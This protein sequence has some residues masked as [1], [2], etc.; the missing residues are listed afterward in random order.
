MLYVRI[1]KK[2]EGLIIEVG[3]MTSRCRRDEIFLENE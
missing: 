2:S 3:G 1:L